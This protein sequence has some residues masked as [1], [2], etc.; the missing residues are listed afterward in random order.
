MA[1]LRIFESQTKVKDPAVAQTGALTIPVGLAT[2]YGKAI[3]SVGAVV[4]KIALENKAEEDANEASDIISEVNKKIAESYNKY[5]KA[6]KADQVLN[7]TTELKNLEY[8]GSNKNVNQLVDKHIRKQSNKLSLDLT[9]VILGNSVS[10][11]RQR[12]KDEVYAAINDITSNDPVKRITGTRDYNNFFKNPENI[13]FYGEEEL[14]KL[15]S[16]YDQ[17]IFKNTFIK[18]I[19]NREIDLLDP[20]VVDEIN[21]QF[22]ELGAKSLLEKVRAREI[23]DILNAEEN[24]KRNEKNQYSNQLNNF[25]FLIDNLNRSKYDK[26]L[27]K[28]TLDQIHDLYDIASLNT[29]Q[30]N[31]LV[32]FYSQGGP[33]ESD[34]ELID[35]INT[36]IAAAGTITDLD[37]IQRALT[38]DKTILENLDP[39]L[40]VEFNNIIEKYKGD[41]LGITD[42][43]KYQELLKS[44]VGDV[45]KVLMFMPK[46]G[47]GSMEKI[48]SM[49]ALEE[50][51]RNIN[52]GLNPEDAYLEVIS[53][54]SEKE[55][56]KPELLPQPIGFDITKDFKQSLNKNPEQAFDQMYKKAVEKFAMDGNLEEYREN[57]K[58]LDFIQDVLAVRKSIFGDLDYLGKFKIKEAKQE[59]PPKKGFITNIKEI[60]TKSDDGN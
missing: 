46:G 51:N 18:R 41:V 40:I 32:K 17:L 38:E 8:D 59:K 13:T 26:S 29:A 16:E 23:S 21:K 45:Q 34:L 60:F 49:N 56:P 44:H 36:Q 58:R 48:K 15:R 43:K 37:N 20:K 50:Y 42:Y 9:K 31:A 47:N 24:E 28:V 1:V 27:T 3:S 33:E 6:T 55:L 53:K 39:N 35:I 5:S 30:Y 4:E 54:F 2:Q 11:S 12:K 25:V 7:F 22:G 19:D 10:K 57:I 14:A 52:N